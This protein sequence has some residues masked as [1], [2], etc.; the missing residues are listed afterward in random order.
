MKRAACAAIQSAG[1][2]LIHHATGRDHAPRIE[3][4]RNQRNR[5]PGA[6]KER[7]DPSGIATPAVA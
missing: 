7:F 4:D 1:D 6:L 3:G 5:G 2:A